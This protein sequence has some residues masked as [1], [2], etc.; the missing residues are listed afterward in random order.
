M[1]IT[2]SITDSNVNFMG[3]WNS[4]NPLFIVADTGELWIIFIFDAKSEFVY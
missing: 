2:E 3:N 1:C 4:R